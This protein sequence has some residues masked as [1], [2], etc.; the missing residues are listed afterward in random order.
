MSVQGRHHNSKRLHSLLQPSLIVEFFTAVT[1]QMA[2]KYT[3]EERLF[4]LQLYKIVSKSRGSTVHPG[5]IGHS[6]ET[7]QFHLRPKDNR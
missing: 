6:Q 5:R 4:L 3:E 1:Q 7:T 2:A